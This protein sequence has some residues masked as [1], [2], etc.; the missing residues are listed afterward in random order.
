[1]AGNIQV[2]QYK[3]IDRTIGIKAAAANVVFDG[4]M[5]HFQAAVTKG[6]VNTGRAARAC[7]RVV[8]D[9]EILDPNVGHSTVDRDA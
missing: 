7:T 4:A 6:C 1:M 3:A 9:G 8:L 2:V 5:L